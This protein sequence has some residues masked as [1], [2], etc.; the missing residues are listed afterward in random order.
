MLRIQLEGKNVLVHRPLLGS[1]LTYRLKESEAPMHGHD[2]TLILVD[3]F[4]LDSAIA[5]AEN[6]G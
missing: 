5:R 4:G 1:E 2:F 3:N 6:H